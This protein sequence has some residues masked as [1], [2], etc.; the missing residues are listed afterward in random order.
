MDDIQRRVHEFNVINREFLMKLVKAIPIDAIVI[1]L[2]SIFASKISSYCFNPNII[3]FSNKQIIFFV[4]LTIFFGLYLKYR[5]IIL[6][7]IVKDWVF[8]QEDFGSS[9]CAK[10]L[11]NLENRIKFIETADKYVYGLYGEFNS[12][13]W[14][15]RILLKSIKNLIEKGVTIEFLNRGSFDIDSKQL[16]KLAID[17]KINLYKVDGDFNN[18]GRFML[19]DKRNVWITDPRPSFGMKKN[20]R[21]TLYPTQIADDKKKLFL[22][23]KSRGTLINKDNVRILKLLIHRPDGS[24]GLAS[25]QEKQSFFN[26]LGIEFNSMPNGSDQS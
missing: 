13:I 21:F 7:S 6:R 2:I 23:L 5:Q 10:E 25:D 3:F 26:F 24:V 22:D 9:S 14:N 8:Y 20:G 16:M 12:D 17:G 1:F 4:V 11:I 19:T 15:N 18:L